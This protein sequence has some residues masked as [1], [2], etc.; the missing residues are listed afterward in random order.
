MKLE[1]PAPLG[2]NYQQE[3]TVVMRSHLFW[4][5]TLA[6]AL[7]ALLVVVVV[8]CSQAPATTPKAPAEAPKAAP[9]KEVK[10][11]VK[12]AK[13]EVKEAKPQKEAS[14]PEKK[15][16]TKLRVAY[17]AI[18]GGHSALWITKEKGLFEKYGLDVELQYIASGPTLVQSMIAGEIGLA[19]TGGGP[20]ISAAVGGAD[21]LIIGGSTQVLVFSLFG[22]SSLSRV[23]D[24]KGKTVGVTRF[25]SATD[26]ALRQTLKKYNLDPE[27]DVSIVQVGGLPEIL[28]ALQA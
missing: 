13:P 3:V 2:S 22:H 11:E 15:Q 28:P 12:E 6:R 8:G 9:P 25:G 16:P 14:P 26:F 10:S 27:K 4:H 23:E 19:Q 7:A 5:S 17:S 21:M 1:N 20:I 18:S 24:L